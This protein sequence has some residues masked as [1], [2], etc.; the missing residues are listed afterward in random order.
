M[1]ASTTATAT[2]DQSHI[3]DLHHSSQ[4]RQ[5]LNLMV[6]SRIRFRCA[7]TGTPHQTFLK[8]LLGTKHFIL[9]PSPGWPLGISNWL[10]TEHLP[11]PCLRLWQFSFRCSSQN[12][13]PPCLLFPSLPTSNLSA[14]P[15]LSTFK[16]HPEF[17]H[18]PLLSQPP[19]P[20]A[21]ITPA[22]SSQVCFHL[23]SFFSP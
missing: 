23:L 20:L 9:A 13:H 14:N 4:Q 6:P 10:Q 22:A 15:V 1:L 8:Q 2:Q 7:T 18:L 3:C 19:T 16:T 11:L 12:G 21:W 17:G 5:I